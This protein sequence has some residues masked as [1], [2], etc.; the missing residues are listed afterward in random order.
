VVI[1][2]AAQDG[3][4]KKERV[5]GDWT[6]V[7]GKTLKLPP[8]VY[9]VTVRNHED[10]GTPELAFPGITVEAG[11]TVDKTAEFSGGGL[12]FN[13]L[14]NGKPFS[15]EVVI[16]KAAQDGDKKKERVIGDWTGV[17]GKTWKLPPG[18]YDVTVRNHEDAAKPELA[19]PGIAIEAGK[20]V[21]KTAQF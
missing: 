15:A 20:T 14:R 19:F 10:A 18:I 12:K 16:Y 3:D 6:G 5:I 7:E 4:K 17:E 21:E 2:K 11:K 9:D 1:Y 8:G 13:A